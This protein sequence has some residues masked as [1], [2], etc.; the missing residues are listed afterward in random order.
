MSWQIEDREQCFILIDRVQHSNL[1]QGNKNN[2]I[3]CSSRTSIKKKEKL[4]IHWNRRQHM[5]WSRKRRKAGD[6]R[7]E[8]KGNIQKAKRRQSQKNTHTSSRKRKA[9]FTSSKSKRFV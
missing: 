1:R 6:E 8:D 7:K 9:D 4:K 3:W 5:C 2:V